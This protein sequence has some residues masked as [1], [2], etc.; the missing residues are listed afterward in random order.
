MFEK[1]PPNRRCRIFALIDSFADAR[2]KEQ[3]WA[4][5]LLVALDVN[6]TKIQRLSE[7]E[8][9]LKVDLQKEKDLL[10]FFCVIIGN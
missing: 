5:K 8:A 6:E 9:N 3:A 10:V 7:E 2:E 1:C 4:D